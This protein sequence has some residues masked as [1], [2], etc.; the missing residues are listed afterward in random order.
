MQISQAGLEA[1]ADREGI[2]LEAYQDQRGIWTIGVGHTA[3]VGA[4]TPRAGLV[5]TREQALST[6]RNDIAGF[7]GNLNFYI[8]VPI[9]Q[10]EYDALC[11]VSFNIGEGG[12][13]GSTI[14]HK[15]NAGD[16]EGAADAFLMW[17]T[18][19]S[20]KGR[21]IS[22]RAQ[23]LEGGMEPRPPA[24]T[25]NAVGSTKWVQISL[26]TLG[27]EPPL[28]VDGVYGGLM[29]NTR[30]A[31]RQFQMMNHLITDG[32]AGEETVSVMEAAL[33]KKSP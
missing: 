15:L 16:I 19:P 14:L 24:A 23:F 31:V 18:P 20:L 9:T 30:T 28:V 21:R 26:N 27:A 22:E 2:R 17:E 12:F 10:D 5:I 11:S 25:V 33:S 6:F 8:R 13:D 3:A 29:S 4:P 32:I 1:L 7:E